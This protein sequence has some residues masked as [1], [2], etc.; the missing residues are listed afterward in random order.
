MSRITKYARYFF[1]LVFSLVSLVNTSFFTIESAKADGCSLDP[2]SYKLAVYSDSGTDPQSI[3][4][5]TVSGKYWAEIQNIAGGSATSD[6]TTYVALSFNL[7]TVNEVNSSGVQGDNKLTIS[8]NINTRASFYILGSESG[9]LVMTATT[10]TGPNSPS[11][12]LLPGTQTALIGNPAPD[13]SLLTFTNN[14]HGT[15]DTISG[16]IGAVAAGAVLPGIK[17]RAYSDAAAT[18]QLGSDANVAIDGSFSSI[19][20]GDDQYRNITLR[21]VYPT[22]VLSDA[23]LVGSPIIVYPSIV[24]G[25]AISHESITDKPYISWD[26]DVDAIGFVVY[27]VPY[28]VTP[29]FTDLDRLT[30]APITTNYYRDDTYV[31]GTKYSYLVK[32]VDSSGSYTPEFLPVKNIQIDITSATVSPAAINLVSAVQFPTV[33]ATVSAEVS[34]LFISDPTSVKVKFNNPDTGNTTYYATV[35]IVGQSLTATAPFIDQATGLASSVLADGNYSSFITAIGPDGSAINDSVQLFNTVVVDLHAPTAPVLSKLQY[36]TTTTVLSGLAGAVEPCTQVYIYDVDPVTHLTALP[37]VS[38]FTSAVDGAFT[39]LPLNSTAQTFYIR[40]LDTAGNVGLTTQFDL[41]PTAPNANLLS[42]QQNKPGTDD[43]IIGLAGTVLSGVVVDIYNV[44]PATNTTATP[45]R[46]IIAGVDGSFSQSVGDNLYDTFWVAVRSGSGLISTSAKLTNVIYAYPVT[47]FS[48][49]PGDGK[50][51]LSWTVATGSSYYTIETYDL[52]TNTIISTVSAPAS[53]SYLQLMLTNDHNYRF[54]IKSY[55][56]YGNTSVSNVVTAIPHAPKIVL[57]SVSQPAEKVVETPPPAPKPVVAQ[58]PKVSAPENVVVAPE[59]TSSK[60]AEESNRNWAPWIL[61][62]G[63]LILLIAGGVAYLL[64]GKQGEVVITE[65]PKVMKNNKPNAVETG[66]VEEV[67]AKE[68]KPKSNS[69]N[70]HSDSG[71]SQKKHKP[72]W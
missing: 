42:L 32:K 8:K 43:V 60:P 2:A 11:Q 30:L 34:A 9:N 53:Q 69:N 35:T 1:V 67:T 25:L 71:N 36:N 26:A 45:Y 68:T 72:R 70:S 49:N 54:T 13:I 24:S 33:T 7:P 44:D 65:K 59:D 15:P 55:D 27:R 41:M 31:L 66:V 51:S 47:N 20:I 3:A 39:S 52:E 6:C 37:L 17:V 62:I 22:E 23:V 58:K 50:V 48:A 19:S 40:T 29:T 10:T 63:I 21:A 57:A 5:N 64:W 46:S 38:A 56:L 28:S 16:N 4:L 14:A 12:Q 61:T 18:V